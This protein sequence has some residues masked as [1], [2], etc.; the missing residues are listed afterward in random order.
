M[1]APHAYRGFTLIEL[2]A[3]I[4]ILAILAAVALP[5]VTA[6]DSFAERGYA[7]E[8]A[9]NL[10]RARIVAMTTGC[11]VQFTSSATG[12]LARQRGAGANN[13]CASAGAW[14]T[15]VFSGPRASHLQ[16]PATRQVVFG[17]DGTAS[18]AVTFTLGTRQVTV[19]T[20]GLV[21]GP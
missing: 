12:F 14:V 19:E 6:A 13:H 3:A 21:S 4:T 7:D 17:R 2:I 20:S 10:R 8:I 5:R 11:D 16:S 1:R 15:T 9:A 18:A